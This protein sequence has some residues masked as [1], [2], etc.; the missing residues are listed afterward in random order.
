MIHQVAVVLKAHNASAVQRH[1][2]LDQIGVADDTVLYGGEVDG[3]DIVPLDI[4]AGCHI[5]EAVLGQKGGGL[6]LSLL[7][8]EDGLAHGTVV[9]D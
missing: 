5:G 3:Q 9:D 4:V 1:R 7:G 8:G 2:H 6:G